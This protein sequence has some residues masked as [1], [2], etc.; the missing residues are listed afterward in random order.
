M[1]TFTKGQI[2]WVEH[3]QHGTIKAK[4]IICSPNHESLCFELEHAVA[5]KVPG[6][7]KIG[8]VLPILYHNGKYK[9]I[10]T[11]EPWTVYDTEPAHKL[12]TK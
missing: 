8:A 5:Y 12:P 11:G 3:P 6:G 10:V 9:D 7:M 4:L 1:I 2:Y